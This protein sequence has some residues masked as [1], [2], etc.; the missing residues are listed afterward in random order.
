MK[1]SAI[2]SGAVFGAAILFAA[3]PA[4]MSAELAFD[5]V[6]TIGSEG[7]G[8]GQ[9]TDPI[10]I[11]VAADGSVWVLD[12]VRS[13]VEHFSPTGKVLGSFDPFATDPINN[14]ANGLAIDATGNLYISGAQ[15][16]TGRASPQGAPE[17]QQEFA[18]LSRDHQAAKDLYD[19]LLKR[20]G[21][22]QLIEKV[23][24]K[25]PPAFAVAV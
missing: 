15:P 25:M 7:T 23:P 6:M 9:F 4:A 2:A 12:N 24:A 20:Y 11:A 1:V 21:D 14:G 5:H 8:P 17:L 22:A 3:L 19:S 16:S 18:L 13:V 10:G